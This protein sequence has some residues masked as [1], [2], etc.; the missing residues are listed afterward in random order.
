MRTATLIC[1][2]IITCFLQSELLPLLFKQAW[3]PNLILTWIIVVALL[4]GRRAGIT[5][6]VIGGLVHD[7]LIS[8][9]FGLHLFPYLV[10]AY[11]L[12]M[13]SHSVYEEQWYVTFF[14]VLGGTLLDAAVRIGMLLMARESV[15]VLIYAW[16]F[17][18][19]VVWLNGLIG[20]GLHELIWNFEK[21][22]EYIW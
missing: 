3:M 17:V 5:V 1:V 6:A 13:W 16:H 15:D 10:V 7:I 8:N 14:W 2:G 4:K 9:L 18:W 22:D 21:D 19:P 12:S 11:V 20:I